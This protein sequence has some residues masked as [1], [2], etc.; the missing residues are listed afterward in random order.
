MNFFNEHF[1][2]AIS[3]LIF[4][5]LIYRPAKNIIFKSLDLKIMAIQNQLTESKK[6]NEDMTLL[7][8]KTTNQLVEIANLKE[9]MLKE[10]EE[11]AN[12]IIIEQN[13]KIEKFLEHK[14]NTTINFVNTAKSKAFATLQSEFCN[15]T[16]ELVSLYMQETDNEKMLDTEIAKKIIMKNT[17]NIDKL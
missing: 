4:V 16:L 11:T 9:K 17:N 6:L 3:F 13:I 5:S 7:F 12:N 14:K 1:W 15:K 8:E 10:G 2:L